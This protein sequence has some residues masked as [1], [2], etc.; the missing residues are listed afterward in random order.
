MGL[1]GTGVCLLRGLLALP[2]LVHD[3]LQPSV[4]AGCKPDAPTTWQGCWAEY[5]PSDNV[6]D[7]CRSF[8]GAGYICVVCVWCYVTHRGGHVNDHCICALLLF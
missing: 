6:A 3:A 7:R 1:A 5:R 2:T 8:G 4:A